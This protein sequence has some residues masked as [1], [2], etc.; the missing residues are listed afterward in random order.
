VEKYST[1][2]SKSQV[3]D[4]GVTAVQPIE[5]SLGIWA[6]PSILLPLEDK[7]AIDRGRIVEVEIEPECSMD[8]LDINMNGSITPKFLT[9]F[10]ARKQSCCV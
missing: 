7:A 10:S 3:I 2:E 9:L 5:T 8:P 6:N 1:T 4:L